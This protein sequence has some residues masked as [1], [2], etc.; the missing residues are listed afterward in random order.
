MSQSKLVKDTVEAITPK[1][2]L[3]RDCQRPSSNV[4]SINLFDWKSVSVETQRVKSARYRRYYAD[5]RNIIFVPVSLC[6]EAI[7]ILI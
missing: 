3:F 1:R 7:P 6:P 4:A 2:L 5:I